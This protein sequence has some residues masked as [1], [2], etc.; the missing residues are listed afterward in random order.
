MLQIGIYDGD[1]LIVDRSIAPLHNHIV[2]ATVDEAFT[3]K[4]LFKRGDDVKLL[5]ENPE[6]APIILKEGQEL[7]VW[8]V[9]T[10]NLHKLLN[11]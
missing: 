6:F 7:R 3:V 10:Y 2:L 11:V 8:G 4:R 5:S 9:V 1:T